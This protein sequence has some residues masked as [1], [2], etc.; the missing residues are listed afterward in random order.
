M[1]ISKVSP[2]CIYRI[3]TVASVYTKVKNP[4]RKFKKIII[5][6]NIKIYEPSVIITKSTKAIGLKNQ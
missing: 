2:I 1:I 6:S 5:E 3:Y 4:V